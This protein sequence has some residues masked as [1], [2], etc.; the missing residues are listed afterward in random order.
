VNETGLTIARLGLNR[1]YAIRTEEGKNLVTHLKLTT[2]LSLWREI[3]NMELSFLVSDDH[4]S[5]DTGCQGDNFSL[6]GR[7]SRSGIG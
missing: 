4:G 3:Q 5:W 7:K 6:N 2:E 1:T